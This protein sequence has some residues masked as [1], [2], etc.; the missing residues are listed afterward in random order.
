MNAPELLAAEL[1]AVRCSLAAV[2]RELLLRSGSDAFAHAEGQALRFLETSKL[3]LQGP[4][5]P[6][7]ERAA[8]VV[9]EIFRHAD[10]G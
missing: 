10:G 1:L 9:R 2:V 8:E 4:T 6:L 5:N 3:G 7:R